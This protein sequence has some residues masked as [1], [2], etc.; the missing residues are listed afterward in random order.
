MDAENMLRAR[1]SELE[2]ENATL[3]D[4]TSALRARVVELEQRGQRQES[5]IMERDRR[6]S[7]L[8]GLLEHSPALATMKFA[9]ALPHVEAVGHFLEAVPSLQSGRELDVPIWALRWTHWGINSK[10]A[11]GEYHEHA[12]ESIF[13]L[14]EQLICGRLSPMELTPEDPLNVYVHWGPDGAYGLYS[15]QN[16]RPMALLMFQACRRDELHRVRCIVRSAE[17]A[18]WGYQWRKGYDGTAGLSIWPHEGRGAA[19]HHRGTRLFGDGPSALAALQRAQHRQHGQPVQAALNT[20]L[21]R[22][23]LRASTA[24][25]DEETLTFAS[26]DAAGWTFAPTA[27]PPASGRASRGRGKGRGRHGWTHR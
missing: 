5:A 7:E 22:A 3:V 11:F 13:K 26:S 17:D 14:F 2:E 15:R 18:H 16:R 21:E 4:G 8:E 24:A 1:V 20:L 12:Q 6:I 9:E 23:H 10:L 27:A 19:A 25:A